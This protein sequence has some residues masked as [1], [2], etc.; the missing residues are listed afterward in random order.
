M[1]ANDARSKEYFDEADIGRI[2][3][4]LLAENPIWIELWGRGFAPLKEELVQALSAFVKDDSR[5]EPSLNAMNL[6]VKL[7]DGELSRLVGLVGYA[8]LSEI[9]VLTQAFASEG[10]D[11]A[12]QL[13]RQ[14]WSKLTEPFVPPA[15]PT[16]PWGSPWWVAGG[17]QPLPLVPPSPLS[18]DALALLQDDEAVIAEHAIL[19]HRIPRNQLEAR[20]DTLREGGFRVAE[21]VPYGL[22]DQRFCF[23][24]ALRDGI[25]S[26]YEVDCDPQQLADFNVQYRERGLK[27]DSIVAYQ[28]DVDSEHRFACVWIDVPS[29]CEL[30]DS[31]MYIQA[32]GDHHQEQGW[33]PLMERQLTLNRSSV[34]VADAEG[35]E[36]ITSIRWH[37]KDKLPY[38]DEW[39]LNNEK[40]QAIQEYRPSDTPLLAKWSRRSATDPKRGRTPIWWLDL[41]VESRLIEYAPQRDHLRVAEQLLEAGFYP[42]SIDA[43]IIGTDTAPQFQSTWW[44][45]LPDREAE[46]KRNRQQ[47][48][49]AIG[50]YQLAQY[51]A[52]EAALTL[53]LGA[54]LRGAVM[55]GLSQSN[56]S[57]D[58]L[59]ERL[60]DV[61]QENILR[62][63]CAFSLALYPINK[64]SSGLRLQAESRLPTA[65]QQAQDP[66]V[67][68]AVSQLAGRWQIPLNLSAKD[69]RPGELPSIAEDRLVIVDPPET[70]WQGSAANEAG[71]DG[72]KEWRVPVRIGHK[73]AIAT[74]EVT[75]AQFRRFKPDYAP[76]RNYAA[77]DDCPAISVSWFEA[78]AYCRWLGEQ[79]W[80]PESQQCYPP[81]DRIRDGMRLPEGYETKSGYRLPTEAEWEF[82]CRGG[83]AD[84]RWFGYDPD[85]LDDYAWTARNSDYRLQPV[86]RRLCNDY[87]LFD[88]LGNGMEWCHSP[89]RP[90]RDS[91]YGPIRDPGVEILQIGSSLPM[92]TRGGAVLY[93][94]L[95][96]RASQR[97]EHR[98]SYR[99]VYLSFRICRTIVEN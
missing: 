52:V 82:A 61:N 47:A 41:P 46:I 10:G 83:L 33:G 85:R 96:A 67:R 60:V 44:R 26:E 11:Q 32:S 30:I 89:P 59:L 45:S 42:V 6:L 92:Q 3:Q 98:A 71:R 14:E 58:W 8:H 28:D 91:I 12:T 79:D 19:L 9:E 7:A 22:G 62:R 35:R 99:D 73:Y 55:A 77:T 86:E 57:P 65:H 75:V 24:S 63:S 50:L 40:Y 72:G 16:T 25:E 69:N 31:D 64:L 54:N 49:F 34:L 93:Q 1:L 36:F 81:G 76:P 56:A 66:G 80:L 97:D 51:D 90:N 15:N 88:M 87:G 70:V 38:A 53:A 23:L 39:N 2:R 68:S 43:T 48:N 95:D 27:P 78:A 17:R 84:S 29:E 5:T 94:P 20:V 18:G 37:T 74:H 21:L 13:M 4:L